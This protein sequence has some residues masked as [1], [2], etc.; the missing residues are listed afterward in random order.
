[1][2]VLIPPSFNLRIEILI[3]DSSQPP[4]VNGTADEFQSQN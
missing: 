1:M 2:P 4:A 3:V